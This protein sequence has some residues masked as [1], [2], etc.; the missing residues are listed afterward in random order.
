[1]VR[2]RGNSY[3]W[4]ILL[5][6]LNI[7]ETFFC[8]SG[9][10]LGK[11]NPP[12]STLI[13][14]GALIQKCSVVYTKTGGNEIWMFSC[15]SSSSKCGDK[16]DEIG[17]EMKYCCCEKENCN[18]VEFAKRCSSGIQ[19]IA[20]SCLLIILVVLIKILAG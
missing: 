15:A 19:N 9:T 12:D 4:F 1:M 7:V 3:T 8:K 5:C 6:L 16:L 17:T 11:V 10:S 18:D 13:C 20:N 14:I 2:T